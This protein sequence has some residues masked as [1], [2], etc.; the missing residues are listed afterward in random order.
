MHS[1][2]DRC[3]KILKLSVNQLPVCD[4]AQSSPRWRH[5]GDIQ[6]KKLYHETGGYS[7]T[8]IQH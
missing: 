5:L 6:S 2:N 3:P 7:G 1:V 4:A 8:G